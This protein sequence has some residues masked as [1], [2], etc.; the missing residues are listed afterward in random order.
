MGISQ[1][2]A[3][4]RIGTTPRIWQNMEDGRAVRDLHKHIAAIADAYNV[5]R[6]WLM[7][8]GNLAPETDGPGG[9]EQSPLSDSDRR[10]LAYN[11]G[12]VT[13]VSQFPCPY[14]DNEELKPAA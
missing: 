1:K 2:E 6:D 8:G 7:W 4:V 11:V 13:S 9:G 14:V 12:T 10:P 3:A 5:D